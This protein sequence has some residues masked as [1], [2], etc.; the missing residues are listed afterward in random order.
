M[1][2]YGLDSTYTLHVQDTYFGAYFLRYLR[3]SEAAKIVKTLFD[4]AKGK[5]IAQLT[6]IVGEPMSII[7][8]NLY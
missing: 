7:L 6:F 8:G 5:D 4:E 2:I 1:C 3:G